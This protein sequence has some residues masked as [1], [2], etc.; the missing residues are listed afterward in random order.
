LGIG[1]PEDTIGTKKK[2]PIDPKLNRG[3]PFGEGRKEKEDQRS[4]DRRLL[5]AFG[6]PKRCNA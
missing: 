1:S 2:I 6:V 4:T 3:V 5:C